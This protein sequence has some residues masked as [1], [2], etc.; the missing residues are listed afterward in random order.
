MTI[1][2]PD[3]VRDSLNINQNILVEN[4]EEINYLFLKTTLEDVILVILGLIASILYRWSKDVKIFEEKVKDANNLTVS[5]FKDK[6]QD[7]RKKYK[8]IKWDRKLWWKENDQD[9]YFWLGFSLLLI[10]ALPYGWNKMIEPNFS[11]F[12]NTSYNPFISA[13]IGYFSRNIINII[14]NRENKIFK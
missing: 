4:Y 13:L 12:N 14:N 6:Y 5:Q 1:L 2:V 11:I 3:L 9:F 8:N 10:I 7:D